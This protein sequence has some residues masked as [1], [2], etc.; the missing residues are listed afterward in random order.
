MNVRRVVTCH[1]EK[2]KSAVQSD[3]CPPRG[4]AFTYTPGMA[5]YLLW[6][7]EANAKVPTGADPTLAV[8]SFHPDPGATRF[9]VLTIP[10]DSVMSDPNLDAVAAGEEYRKE[11]PGIVDRF[12]PDGMH[13]T[14]TI[15]YG[16]VLEGELWLELDDG[17]TL[18]LQ[19]HD[20]VVQNG[21][22]HGWR[23]KSNT[24]AT[25]AFVLVGVNRHI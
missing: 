3:G 1:S 8:R 9:I 4:K 10:P 2:G 22:R 14:D 7:T 5:Q 25:I 24:P 6:A 12:E 13:T 18:H 11:T 15:D 17:H 16:I 23:N 21:T 20:C 19:Q